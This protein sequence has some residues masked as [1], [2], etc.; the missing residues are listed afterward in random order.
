MRS[1]QL[2]LAF[3]RHTRHER[4]VSLARGVHAA[5]P[6]T[7]SK[8]RTSNAFCKILLMVLPTS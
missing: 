4:E 7:R 3:L 6:L 2:G 8:V 1:D 5:E